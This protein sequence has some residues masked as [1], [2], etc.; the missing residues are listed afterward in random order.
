[1]ILVK[2]RAPT[3]P[4]AV[5]A[6]FRVL[7]FLLVHFNP[8]HGGVGSKGCLTP[9]EPPPQAIRTQIRERILI[10]SNRPEPID[11]GMRPNAPPRLAALTGTRLREVAQ[12]WKAREPTHA[13]RSAARRASEMPY[14]FSSQSLLFKS[15]HFMRSPGENSSH[16]V[17]LSPQVNIFARDSLKTPLHLLNLATL[18]PA[19]PHTGVL[20]RK[21]L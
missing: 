14:L 20:T 9:R 4:P 18:L 1:M 2:I 16:Q 10:Y 5:P 6:T 17:P 11:P 3:K 15:L 8:F 13:D 7:A 12:A 21:L 19:T